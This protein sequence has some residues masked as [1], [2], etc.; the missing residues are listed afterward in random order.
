MLLSLLLAA[1]LTC[2]TERWAQKTMTDPEA[3][4]IDALGQAGANQGVIP[5]HTTVHALATL[6]AVCKPT[7]PRGAAP[8][9][10]HT[11]QVE[12]II[13]LAKLESDRDV[14]L[15]LRDPLTGDTMI[16]EVP[17]PACAAGS[18][19]LAK[20]QEVRKTIL[21]L[22]KG[23]LSRNALRRLRGLHVSVIGT[24]FADFAHGQSGAAPSCRELH[25][26]IGFQVVP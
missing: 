12:A 16:G 15:V 26:L 2:G 21:T 14:H 10:F 6:P 9:E 7:V 5:I 3:T 19:V 13:T 20:L 17:D 4:R 24:G 11:Y 22:T 23:S 1:G 25:P 18:I 8:E